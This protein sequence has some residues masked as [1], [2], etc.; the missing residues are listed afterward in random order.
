MPS[1]HAALTVASASCS[2]NVAE[3]VAERR[4]AESEPAGQNVLECHTSSPSLWAKQSVRDRGP[5][6][7]LPRG[8]TFYRDPRQ[9]VEDVSALLMKAATSRGWDSITAWLLFNSSHFPAGSLGHSPLRCRRDH[10][11][12]TCHHIVCRLRSSTPPARFSSAP[13][14]IPRG[15]ARQLM[16]RVVAMS[17][18]AANDAGNLSDVDE[19]IIALS[20]ERSLVFPRWCWRFCKRSSPTLRHRAQMP[21]DRRGCELSD[22]RLLP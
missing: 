13:P 10:M 21:R 11:I 17:T 16:K 5:A 18:S 14:A 22:Y 1:S 20:D 4:R 9:S 2:G 6:R 8:S 19:E 15:V 7:T 3:H 12:I